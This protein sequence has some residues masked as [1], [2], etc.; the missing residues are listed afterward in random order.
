MKPKNT[1]CLWY[2]KD[3]LDAANFYA[4]T[5]PNSQVTS[6]HKAPSDFPSII[7][8]IPASQLISG[9]RRAGRWRMSL[10][11][12]LPRMTPKPIPRH[13]APG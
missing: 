9:M 4:A 1:I 6:V 13:G 2:D 11:P 8:C 7:F 12:I 3:A 10:C 5:F